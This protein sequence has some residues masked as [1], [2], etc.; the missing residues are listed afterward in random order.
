MSDKKRQTVYLPLYLF[1]EMDK[2]AGRLNK[3]FSWLVQRCWKLS[4]EEIEKTK[5][6]KDEHED[7]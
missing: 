6:K 5:P 4:K 7:A 3:S 2:Q 1:E